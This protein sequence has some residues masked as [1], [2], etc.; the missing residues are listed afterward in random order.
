MSSHTETYKSPYSLL[1]LS[2]AQSDSEAWAQMVRKKRKEI[3]AEFDLHN[4]SYLMLNGQPWTRSEVLAGFEELAQ[5][6]QT[7]HRAIWELGWIDFWQGAKE[8]PLNMSQ[9]ARWSGKHQQALWNDFE[10]IISQRLQEYIHTKQFSAIL[11]LLSF[12]FAV[13]S[14]VLNKAETPISTLLQ[15]ERREWRGRAFKIRPQDEK[16]EYKE[17][18]PARYAALFCQLPERYEEASR[19]WAQAVID[20]SV[21]LARYLTFEQR[22]ELLILKYPANTYWPEDL[23]RKWNRFQQYLSIVPQADSVVQKTIFYKKKIL[24]VFAI[25]IGFMLAGYFM[26]SVT[27]SPSDY[28]TLPYKYPSLEELKRQTFQFDTLEQTPY[29]PDVTEQYPEIFPDSIFQSTP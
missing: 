19:Q 11:E 4:A 15:E 12:T 13:P 18:Y 14:G 3:L 20:I 26:G 27:S 6:T 8:I 9:E 16:S 5:E 25:S 7:I 29:A 10:K 24:Q 21:V 28:R 22:D 1:N 17:W 23:K 2:P